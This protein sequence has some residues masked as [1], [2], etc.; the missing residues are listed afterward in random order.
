MGMLIMHMHLHR[1][2][3]RR[4]QVTD[5][6]AGASYTSEQR[7]CDALLTG[8][9]LGSRRK[10]PVRGVAW[11]PI[12]GCIWGTMVPR[13]GLHPGLHGGESGAAWGCMWPRCYVRTSGVVRS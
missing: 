10:T 7:L 3:L 1:Q 13:L 6:P 5:R 9:C 12:W 4:I 2:L 8:V 11:G